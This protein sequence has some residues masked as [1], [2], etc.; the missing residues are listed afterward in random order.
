[1]WDWWSSPCTLFFEKRKISNFQ[2]LVT[3]SIGL[4]YMTYHRTSPINLH[5]MPYFTEV[6]WGKILKVT[7]HIWIVF[8]VQSRV[9]QELEEISKIR[10]ERIWILCSSLRIN[11]HLPAPKQTVVEINVEWRISNFQALATLTLT[12]NM[13]YYCASVIDLFTHQISLESEELFVDRC[14]DGHRTG[15]ISRPNENN[16]R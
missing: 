6:R 9:T 13:T 12:L 4:G 2:R 7:R 5:N 8:E 16:S 1:M 10:P 14:T 3:L 15:S 11:S